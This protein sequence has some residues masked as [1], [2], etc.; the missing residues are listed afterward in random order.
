MEIQNVLQLA[1]NCKDLVSLG[2]YLCIQNLLLSKNKIKQNQLYVHLP[3]RGYLSLICDNHWSHLAAGNMQSWLMEIAGFALY[4]AKMLLGLNYFLYKYEW[5]TL[6]FWPFRLTWLKG[7]GF[8][9]TPAM[10]FFLWWKRQHVYFSSRT[11]F[12]PHID[13]RGHFLA[14]SEAWEGLIATVRRSAG[15]WEGFHT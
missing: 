14:T 6:P 2:C 8:L 3:F 12:F 4:W 15:C 9:I 10:E 7:L 5:M 11:I 1:F 13:C